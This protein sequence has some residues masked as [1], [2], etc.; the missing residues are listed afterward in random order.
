MSTPANPTAEEVIRTLGLVPHPRE[1]G[2][3]VETYRAG[4]SVS[5]VALPP[6]YR[7]DGPARALST[8]IYYLLTPTTFSAVHRLRSDEVF[9]FYLGDV[10]EMLRLSP[11]GTGGVLY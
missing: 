8:C 5:V 11:D 2:H 9:H 3:F 10:V 4:E 7:S 6:R 1:G